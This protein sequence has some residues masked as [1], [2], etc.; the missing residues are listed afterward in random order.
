MRPLKEMN[1][2]ILIPFDP[3]EGISLGRAALRA[4][5]SEST[6]RGWCVRRGLGR[7]V[8][9]GVWVVSKVALAMYLDDD[10][11]ALASYLAGDRSNHRV[12]MYFERVGVPLSEGAE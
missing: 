8:G 11:N 12:K 4:G 1:W 3:R 2:Q 5:K 10:H 9:N 6:V 7:R